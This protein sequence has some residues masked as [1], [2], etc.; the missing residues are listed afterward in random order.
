MTSLHNLVRRSHPSK[1]AITVA[2]FVGVVAVPWLGH[3]TV[4]GETA[5]LDT[6]VLLALRKAS[7]LNVPAGPHWLLREHDQPRQSGRSGD[8]SVLHCFASVFGETERCCWFSGL[9][10]IRSVVYQQCGEDASQQTP[11]FH[12]PASGRGS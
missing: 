7:D 6:R 5:S 9:I 8:D 4:E 2:L 11:P 3:E 1:I 12:R 10:G